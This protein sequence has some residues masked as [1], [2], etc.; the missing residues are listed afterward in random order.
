MHKFIDNISSIT[1]EPDC[2]VIITSGAWGAHFL[3]HYFD[4]IQRNHQLC[5]DKTQHRYEYTFLTTE[6]DYNKYKDRFTIPDITF[7]FWRTSSSGVTGATQLEYAYRREKPVIMIGSDCLHTT[8]LFNSL[9]TKYANYDAVGVMSQRVNFQ[10]V[11]MIKTREEQIPYEDIFKP[12]EFLK[13]CLPMLHPQDRR[14]FADNYTGFQNGIF[15][16]VRKD[17]VLVGELMRAFHWGIM[18]VKNPIL[19]FSGGRALDSNEFLCKLSTPE[20]IGLVADSDDGFL[21]DVTTDRNAINAQD[22]IGTND[23]NLI[24]TNLGAWFRSM[25]GNAV[26]S[27]HESLM[28]FNVAIHSES[29]DQEWLDL[30]ERV[31]ELVTNAYEGEVKNKPLTWSM[32]E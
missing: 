31:N 17:G 32:L 1:N 30:A 11:D 16:P 10:I 22:A 3:E 28:G 15:W 8:N 14:Y 26:N 25:R 12:R 21:V 20:N 18:Y 4:Y 19:G 23:E 9:M 13:L 6:Q 7:L 29:L 24:T 5:L 2:D 27:V